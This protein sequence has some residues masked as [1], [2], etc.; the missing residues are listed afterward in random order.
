M[1][2]PA[3]L[4][5]FDGTTVGHARHEH[6]WDRA[7]SRRSFIRGSAAVTGLALAVGTTPLGVA[8]ASPASLPPPQPIPGGINLA[9]FGGPDLLLHL[10]PPAAGSELITITDFNGAMGAA[11]VQG[12]GT[13]TDGATRAFDVDMRFMQGEYISA[14]G[15]H[16]Y[17]TFGFI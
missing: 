16:A 11:E 17:A 8:A 2:V 4:S 1:R 7:V 3:D 6:F 13:D 9:D 10:F 14:K 5:P 15:R 12:L